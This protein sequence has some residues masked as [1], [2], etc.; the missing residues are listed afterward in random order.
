MS[1][2][3]VR[4]WCPSAYRPMASGDGLVVRVRP[5]QGKL[6]RFQARGLGVLARKFGNGLIDL[7]SRANLQL[8]GVTQNGHD[9]L[10]KELD[11]L[12]LL[13][14]DANSEGRLNFVVDPL[15][16]E[17]KGDLQ[18]QITTALGDGLRAPEFAPLPSKFGFVVDLG[19]AR[20]LARVSGDIRIE[21]GEG[22][23][24]VRADGQT[25]GLAVPDAGAAV[26][27]ALELA[28]WFLVSEGVGADGRGRMA[29]HIASGA[30]VPRDLIGSTKPNLVAAEPVPGVLP[31]GVLV[32]AAFGQLTPQALDRLADAAP[33]ELRITPWRMVFLTGLRN[34][35]AFA[36]DDAL[37]I[38]PTDPVLRV[39]ACPGAP[40]CSQASVRTRSIARALAPHV[41]DGAS[42]HVSGCA[43]GCAHPH[44]TDLTLVGNDGRF[45][46]VKGGLP[47]DDPIRRQLDQRHAADLIGG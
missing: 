39:H 14:A 22:S 8:R 13:D 20:H 27:C 6:T 10:L 12:G 9:A 31:G 18:A 4:G 16:S 23:L 33:I 25:L 11:R 19:S 41:P 7:T 32:A 35:Q 24:I 21:M 36:T 28:R 40:S 5:V 17:A 29:R 43:K 46:L 42:L 15:C 38:D 1:A 47:W 37:I 34:D 2:P 30:M 3:K 45:D 44:P 26:A